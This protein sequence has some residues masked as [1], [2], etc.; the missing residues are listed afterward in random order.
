M[1][2]IKDA[3]LGFKLRI[4]KIDS[5]KNQNFTVPLIDQYIQQAVLI[6]LEKA[7]SKEEDQ[8]TNDILSIFRKK[9]RIPV[10]LKNNIYEGE[11]PSD[12][13]KRENS[14]CLAKKGKCEKMLELLD[15]N[16]NET[17]QSL[18]DPFF[19]PSFNWEESYLE[20]TDKIYI[21]NDD[22]QIKEII[23]EYI[24]LPKKA[25]N[26]EDFGGYTYPSGEVAI[27]QDLEMDDIS[28]EKVLDLAALLATMDI[29]NNE[30]F[31]INKLK[32]NEI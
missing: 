11:I 15:V 12:Y 25:A 3:H 22:F 6:W 27:Q 7:T 18:K 10:K 19:K 4:N 31:K 24:R 9:E 2:N 21:Y 28:S 23:L 16:R 29:N 26:P 1:K 30:S 20:I 5:L 8:H 14:Y 32:L 17:I 13:Y